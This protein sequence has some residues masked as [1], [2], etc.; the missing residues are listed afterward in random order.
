MCGLS[1][2]IAS[3]TEMLVTVLVTE[4][5]TLLCLAVWKAHLEVEAPPI[6]CTEGGWGGVSYLILNVIIKADV[7]ET[8]EMNI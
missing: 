3:L 7:V 1:G 8:K 5:T 2:S 4:L 6:L